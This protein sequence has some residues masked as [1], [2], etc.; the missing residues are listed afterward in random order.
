MSNANFNRQ[1]IMLDFRLLEDRDFLEFLG[2]SEFATYLVLRRNVWRSSQPHFMGLHTTRYLK[3]R[4]LACSL[5][6]EQIAS[7]TGIDADNISRHLSRLV[8]KDVIKRIST[9]RQNIYLLGEW[10][11]VHADGTY[12]L[13]WFYLEGQYGI[14]K[15]DLTHSVRSESAK[16]S[17]QTRRSA[18]GQTRR[19]ASDNNRE[20]NREKKT[21][22]GGVKL[23]KQMPNLQQPTARQAYVV[24]H[25][26]E[27][28]GDQ[29]S[30][31]FYQL[32]ASRVPEAEL[33][34]MLSEIKADGARQ[35]ERVFTYKVQQ[36]AMEQ[37]RQR[38]GQAG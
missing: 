18:S 20:E 10:V 1:F 27:E 12:K 19:S 16:T 5:E 6:R 31:R 38:I 14:A 11:D 13:E 25:I 17:E 26:L 29:H 15:A 2:S 23:L 7:V 28:L 22:N 21:V 9:G 8:K 32:V 35:P 30:Q 34:R 4:Q 24:A 36:Y 33:R 37:A 3:E